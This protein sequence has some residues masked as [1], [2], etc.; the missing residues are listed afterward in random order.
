MLKEHFLDFIEIFWPLLRGEKSDYNHQLK[1][2]DIKPKKNDDK[3]VDRCIKMYEFQKERIKTVE[4]KS[5]IFIGFFGSIITLL[6]I[7]LKE[8]ILKSSK[9][10]SDYFFM[11]IISII[12]IYLSNVIWHAVH[13]LE[14]KNYHSFD[15]NDFLNLKNEEQIQK[16]LNKIKLNYN[17]INEKVDSMTLAQEFSKKI[18]FIIIF[19]S[20]ILVMISLI[21]LFY[22]KNLFFDFLL[23][24]K[25]EVYFFINLFFTMI[26]YFILKKNKKQ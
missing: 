3:V 19:I 7:A 20:I 26:I 1:L 10:N 24:H 23:Q 5:M 9:T 8:I 12:V 18:I 16:I 15:E 4:S 11:F 13:A 21:N 2:E 25:A 17:T 6:G 14:R 22:I